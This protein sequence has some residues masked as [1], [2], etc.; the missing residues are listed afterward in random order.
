MKWWKQLKIFANRG[1]YDKTRRKGKAACYPAHFLDGNDF[2]FFG[3]TSGT[4][5][6]DEHFGR[7]NNWE[8]S[9]TGI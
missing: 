8:N 1:V 3:E 5:L 7:K 6:K 2:L 9:G 4:V